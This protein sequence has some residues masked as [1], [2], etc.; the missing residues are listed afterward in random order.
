MK[1]K[2]LISGRLGGFKKAPSFKID[3]PDKV[4]LRI[5]QA[6]AFKALRGKR[7]AILNAPT[8]WGKTVGAL[9]I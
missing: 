9:R 7:H 8:G 4:V 6:K 5:Q 3:D 2:T 1:Q